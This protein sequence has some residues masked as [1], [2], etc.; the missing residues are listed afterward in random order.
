MLVGQFTLGV[1]TV[2][3]QKPADITSLHVAIGALTAMVAGLATAVI[4]RQYALHGTRLSAVSRDTLSQQPGY[5][6]T[7]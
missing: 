6:V 2:Y 1:L 4:G 3:L 7:A 5:V